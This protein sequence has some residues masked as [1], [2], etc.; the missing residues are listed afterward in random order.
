MLPATFRETKLSILAK[1]VNKIN[2]V[3]DV[4]SEDSFYLSVVHWQQLGR[5]TSCLNKHCCLVRS[6]KSEWILKPSAQTAQGSSLSLPPLYR[7]WSELSTLARLYL[8]QVILFWISLYRKL[9]LEKFCWN[10]FSL[11]SHLIGDSLLYWFG[12][13]LIMELLVKA[14]LPITLKQ[15]N[16]FGFANLNMSAGTIPVLALY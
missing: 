12:N 16:L 6:N 15:V 8:G 2:V 7:V 4:H 13:S 9:E 1:K 11:G 5:G 10:V 14:L 3:R